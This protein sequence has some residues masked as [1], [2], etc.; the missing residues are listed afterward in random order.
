[1]CRLGSVLVVSV[2][3]SASSCGRT[4]LNAVVVSAHPGEGGTIAL[5]GVTGAGGTTG[6][7]GVVP[8]AGGA[9]ASGGVV[10]TGAATYG[11]HDDASTARTC[12][13]PSCMTS[14]GKD[15]LPAGDCVQQ[16]SYS[17]GSANIC[18]SNGVKEIIGIDRSFNASM[19]VKNATTTCFT[20]IGSVLPLMT[21]GG[22]V[23][24]SLQNAAG[25]V[26]GSVT[27]DLSTNQLTVT[28]TDSQ[29]VVLDPACITGLS[30][31]NACTSGTCLP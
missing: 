4:D 2:L 31:S 1:M 16:G 5:G 14:A 9:P 24:M 30:M 22:V 11:S 3:V 18:Y 20:M 28:C 29:P 15:C 7:G 26:I 8:G 19:T 25:N 17:T 21:G 6:T 27:Q 12:N 13:W 10:G 23:T